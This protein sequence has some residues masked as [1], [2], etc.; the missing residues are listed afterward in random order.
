MANV[1]FGG[2][3]PDQDL[4][5]R[6]RWYPVA[7]NYG[8][9]LFN[10]DAC[11]ILTDGTVEAA[12]AGATNILGVIKEVQYN[13]GG[14]RVRRPYLPANTTYSGGSFG[15]DQSQVWVWDD[16]NQEFWA[17]STSNTSTDT[18]AEWE[19]AVGSNMDITATAGNTTYGRSGH[20]LDGTP[21]AGTA[22]FR[23]LEVKRVPGRSLTGANLHVKVMINE[24]FHA[25]VDAAGI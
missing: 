23:I 19:A 10:G 18:A 20:V 21:V 6:G 3:H 8:T 9:A 22:Q 5:S 17:C 24:G 16:P 7:S 14:R 2:F 11:I 1:L 4:R 13:T 15:A 12:T 25:F